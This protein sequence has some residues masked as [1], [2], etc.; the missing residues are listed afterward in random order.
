MSDRSRLV[1]GLLLLGAMA[2]Y[3]SLAFRIRTDI[4]AFL[5]AG[6]DAALASLSK[7]LSDSELS[8][9]AVLT[10]ASDDLATGIT[11][12]VRKTLRSPCAN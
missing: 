1:V 10:I 8:R 3:V 2:I 5:P 9:T 7:H 4:T 11:G 12:A 6:A